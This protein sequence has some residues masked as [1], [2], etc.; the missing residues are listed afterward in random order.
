MT[1]LP[2]ARARR[3]FLGAAAAALAV[4]A[5]VAPVPEQGAATPVIPT[6]WTSTPA[7]ATVLDGEWG[8]DDTHEDEQ[9]SQATGYWRADEDQGS[10]YWVAKHYG[11]H[12]AWTQDDPNGRKVTGKGVTVA[13]VDTG[14]SP[15]PGL[16]TA[17]KVVNGPDL[18]FES[19][20]EGTRYLD[21]YGHGTHMAAII[22]GRDAE[23]REGNEHDARLFVGVAPDA[24]IL[25]M[26]VATAD[27]G[28]DVSQ[29][30]A[31]IDWI[32][33][34]R[35]DN[36]MDVRVINLSYGT[37]SVQSYELDPLAHAVENAWRAG[38][39]VVVAAGNDGLGQP[40]LTMPAVDPYVLAVGAVD[41]R[42]TPD[43]QDDVVA[44]FTNGGNDSRRPDLLAPGKS[45]VSLRVPG[46]A[47][48][49]GHPEGLVTGD[50]NTRLFRGSG[51]SQAAAVV[52]GAAALLLQ[53]RPE[54]TPDQVKALL[55]STASP[56]QSDPHPA[57]G[58]G[59]LD[60]QRALAANTPDATAVRQSWPVST[61]LGSLEA[62]RGGEH[63]VDPLN[64]AVL[65]GEVDAL[66]TPWDARSWSTASAAGAAWSG[67]EWNARSWSGSDWS[68]RSWSGAA[69]AAR[70]W[71]GQSW[72]GQ[73][74]QA[75]SWSSGLWEAR[76]WSDLDWSARSWSEAAWVA[77]SWSGDVW[78]L[79]TNW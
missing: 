16:D 76:S 31:A 10:L 33:Q 14:V 29:V 22:A 64:E 45:L 55:E 69:W 18:S 4:A 54:L 65:T 70:S 5:G 78:G 41:H 57:M 24:Q 40:S 59:V 23:V 37:Q 60:V 21:G 12:Q 67:G 63:V 34:H 19:Q 71:S 52:S 43:P 30:I 61:G 8:D 9:A 3:T 38:I 2:R 49:A 25:N 46:S 79:S 47:A 15:V 17:G 77:R 11:A 53:D 48:D 75:R 39:V 73:D 6:A 56:L 58:A 50:G 32:V 44:A 62:S 28:T 35:R 72:S 66:G 1:S 74:W 20:V 7:A 68:A 42:G 26:K 36:G 27:G 51:T 13:V